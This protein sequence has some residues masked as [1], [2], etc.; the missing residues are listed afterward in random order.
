M[1]LDY[2]LSARQSL[3]LATWLNYYK[4]HGFNNLLNYSTA[5]DGRQSQLYSRAT[6]NLFSGFNG[7]LTGTCTKTVAQARREWSVLGQYARNDGTFGYDFDQYKDS[8]AS[9]E[10][11]RANL[12]ERSRGRTPGSETTFQTDRVQ[13]FGDK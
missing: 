3:S 1:G 2:D 9:L 4:G 5:T 12:R 6:N 8:C 7:E 11:S 13:P 10:T